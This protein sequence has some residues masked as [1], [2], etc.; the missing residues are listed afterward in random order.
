MAILP[1]LTYPGP[2]LKQIAKPV[3]QF[4]EALATLVRDMTDTMYDAPGV[5]LA[6]P[7][8]G[9]SLQL[10]IVDV[11]REDDEK[12]RVLVLA[13]PR[14]VKAEGEEAGEEGCLSVIDY[15][16]K[17]KRYTKI[18]VEAQDIKG[19]KISF[20]AEEFFA[21]VI[22]HELDHLGGNLFIDRIS[23]LKRSLYKK[24]LKK[25]LKKQKEES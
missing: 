21:R 19:E 18:W 12:K 10:A 8:I 23:G 25:I 20:A 1:I 4:D 17:V 13:N 22:Q 6:A 24:K 16:S 11:S 15:S 5:G 7:Q 2:V 9:V 3:T 14:I